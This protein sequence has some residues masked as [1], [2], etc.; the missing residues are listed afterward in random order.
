VSTLSDEQKDRLS[1]LIEQVAPGLAGKDRLMAS[2][3]DENGQYTP[4]RDMSD[5]EI[6]EM[7]EMEKAFLGL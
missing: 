6:K 4:L 3:A 7:I 5:R 1:A 2:I